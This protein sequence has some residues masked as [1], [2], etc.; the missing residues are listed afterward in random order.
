MDQS[1]LCHI[2]L[3]GNSEENFYSLGRRDKIG[4]SEV[5]EQLSKLCARSQYMAKVLK[6][7]TELGKQFSQKKNFELQRELIAY[8][9]GLEKPI[10]DVYFTLLLPELVA[11][12]NKWLP[13]LLGIIPGCSS[14][15]V[16]DQIHGGVIHGRI[17]DYALSGPFEKYERAI[18]Y[19]FK[20]RLK[21]FSYST[22][23]MPFPSLSS[24]NE[25]GLTLALHYKHG[26][27]F[28]INGESIFTIMYQLTSYCVN[29]NE[30]KKYLKAHPSIGHWGIYASDAS[31]TVASFDIRGS[32]V[33]QEKFDLNEHKYLY[34]NNRP[35]IMGIDGEKIQPYGNQDQ[36]LMR[37][38][39]LKENMA[40]FNEK[41]KDQSLE[42]LKTLTLLKPK[43][44]PDATAWKLPTV[45][46]SSIQA[47]TLHTQSMR[48]LYLQGKAPKVFDG[49]YLEFTEL[50]ND[51]KQ[52]HKHK[53]IINDSQYIKGLQNMAAAQSSMDNGN[54]EAAYHQLQM[55]I[56][57]LKDYPEATICRFFFLV[58]QYLFESSL[59]DLSYLYQDFIAL[60]GK[61]SPYLND[62]RLLF[63]A[64]LGKILNYGIDHNLEGAIKNQNLKL[65]YQKEMKMKASAIKLL[66]KFIV[67]RIEILDIIYVYA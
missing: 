61:L 2:H 11:S 25:K 16:K 62:H 54:I 27:Y 39:F 5:Y 60:E 37:F 30:V 48:S 36:C 18:S 45:T 51:V 12:F 24:V 55:S 3:F 22:A 52:E 23:G 26:D 57:Y 43:K 34:F 31:G 33:Y 63:I 50:F 47:V 1:H 21:T 7:L 53:K 28:D 20:D 29:V 42:V 40:S 13:H 67:P 65:I 17:L 15:F 66:R 8:A 38:D 32:E 19:N 46:P 4:H 58:W 59:K 35:L 10:E 6:T 14:L 41:A 9:D 64:R 56:E 44:S 49:N